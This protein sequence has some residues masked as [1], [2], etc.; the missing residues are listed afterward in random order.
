MNWFK[1]LSSDDMS[2]R[3]KEWSSGYPYIIKAYHGT[4][5]EFE[6]FK[7]QFDEGGR[8]SGLYSSDGIFFAT[9]PEQAYPFSRQYP[10][11][12]HN[13]IKEINKLEKQHID[14]IKAIPSDEIPKYVIEDLSEFYT[15]TGTVLYEGLD[16]GLLNAIVNFDKSI[17]NKLSDASQKFLQDALSILKGR[18]DYIDE[19]YKSMRDEIKEKYDQQEGYIKE[20]YIRGK[21]IIKVNGEDIGFDWG[22]EQEIDNLGEDDI[23]YIKDADTG[24]YIGDEIVI[25]NP[26]NI[27]NLS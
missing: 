15:M 12:F 16:I 25:T 13:K 18:Y 17:F 26:N 1:K 19:K 3:Y 22:R 10:E 4:P 24:Q 21:N 2:D 8:R 27:F 14:K 23:L 5:Y 20:V 7:G 6:Q 9:T 11:E